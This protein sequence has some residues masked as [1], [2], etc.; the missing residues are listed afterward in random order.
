MKRSNLLP[1]SKGFTLVELLVVVVIIIILSALGFQGYRMAR[2]RANQVVST[3]NLRQLCAANLLYAAEHLTYCLAGDPG[4]YT[5]WHG[6]RSS[7]QGKFDPT[8]GYLSEYLGE[9]RSIGMCPEFKDHLTDG[10]SWEDGSGGYGYNSVYLGGYLESDNDGNP[11]PQ[12][13]ANVRNPARTLMFATTAA[14]V[15]K[16]VQEYPFADPPRDATRRGRLGRKLQ[17]SVHFRFNGR[18]LIAWCD[19]HVSEVSGRVNSKTNYFGGDNEGEKIGFCGP[20]ANNGWWN[21]EN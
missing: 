7:L 11:V 3:A 14:A 16:G 17:P 18:A 13:P 1:V 12:R 20:A 9:S 8:Q 19:G 2:V 4:N 21:P 10:E 6:A 5:R 15:A